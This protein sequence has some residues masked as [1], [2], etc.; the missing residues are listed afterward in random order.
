MTRGPAR[1]ATLAAVSGRSVGAPVEPSTAVAGRDAAGGGAPPLGQLRG[2]V[3]W[4]PELERAFR[5]AQLR[6]DGRDAAVVIGLI[7]LLSA[8]FVSNDL[9]WALPAGRLVD[10]SVARLLYTA[11]GLAVVAVGLRTKRPAWLDGVLVA[12]G[13]IGSA[14]TI[15]LQSTRPADYYLPAMWNAVWVIIGWAVVP[16]RFALQALCAAALTASCG[17]W[18]VAFRTPPTPQV[19]L[20]LVLTFVMANL[21]GA[22]LSRRLHRSR[23]SQ[24]LAVR[25]QAAAG[26]R[27]ARATRLAAL[28]RLVGGLAHEVNNPLAASM[29]S[30]DFASSELDALRE[31]VRSGQPVDGPSFA[32]RLD[33]VREAVEDA[34][35]AERR[36]AALV[37]D[38]T[39]LG[40][41]DAARA[42]VAL[43]KV[44]DEALAQLPEALRAKLE[45]RVEDLGPREVAGARGQLI[46]VVLNLLSNAAH[47][48]PADRKVQVVMRLAPGSASTSLLEVTDDG[49]GMDEETLARA[50]DPFFTTRPVGQGMGLG[51]AICQSIVTAHGGTITTASA[52]GRGTCVK[53]ELPVALGV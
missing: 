14:L 15:L 34:R 17:A 33:E 13:L 50:Y 28:G 9:E 20:L 12:N 22:F 36:I 45:L 16:N 6:D 19:A 7:T 39:I 11:S 24:F 8:A 1:S 4:P 37:K 46:Q 38:L 5:L 21:A 10:H 26:E 2:T 31:A 49:V 27:L 53:V 18:V 51:L 48:A 52:V 30:N 43:P 25:E 41:P 23:R 47:A 35:D 29:A 42:R 3:L 44:V 40:R 32:R